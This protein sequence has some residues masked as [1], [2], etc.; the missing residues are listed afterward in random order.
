MQ[1]AKHL[2]LLH[3]RLVAELGPDH[4]HTV[5]FSKLRVSLGSASMAWLPYDCL[6]M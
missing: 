4:S 1:G 6:A 5:S 3:S 2:E